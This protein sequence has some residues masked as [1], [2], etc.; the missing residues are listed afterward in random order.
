MLL[1]QFFRNLRQVSEETF[2]SQYFTSIFNMLFTFYLQNNIIL[3][4]FNILYPK[5]HQKAYYPQM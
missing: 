2:T 3:L 1:C 4:T 5:Y